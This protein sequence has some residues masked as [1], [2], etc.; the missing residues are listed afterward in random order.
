MKTLFISDL[1]LC[2]KYSNSSLVYDVLKREQPDT[3]YIVGDLFDTWIRYPLQESDF[4]LL[5]YIYNNIKHIYVCAGN[6][7]H[8]LLFFTFLNNKHLMIKSEFLF[9]A[10]GKRYLVTHGHQWDRSMGCGRLHKI[11]CRIYNWMLGIARKKLSWIKPHIKKI[12]IPHFREDIINFLD[13]HNIY[14]S[15]KPYD[16]IIVGHTHS[17]EC[18]KIGKF[19]Y[20]NCGDFIE[21]NTYV[22]YKNGQFILKQAQI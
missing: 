6:H 4:T 16:G 18:V 2:T 17:P 9:E 14:S 20:I 7:D 10:D 15:N 5:S 21:H 8:I 11:G 1:H 22:V 3:L 13:Q 19:Q 12:F